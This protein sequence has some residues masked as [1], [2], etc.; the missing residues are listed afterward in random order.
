MKKLY[1][2]YYTVLIVL[3]IVFSVALYESYQEKEEL[4]GVI[5]NS[6]SHIINTTIN[7]FIKIKDKHSTITDETLKEFMKNLELEYNDFDI[8]FFFKENKNNL[9]D[10]L[11][12]IDILEKQGFYQTSDF[13]NTTY[14]LALKD[15]KVKEE[16]RDLFIPNTK[17][18]IGVLI[19]KEDE[20][21]DNIAGDLEENFAGKE[22]LFVGI[23]LVL[24]IGG[25]FLLRIL[26]EKNKLEIEKEV[27]KKNEQLKSE[28]LANMSHEIRTPLNAMFGFIKLLEEKVDDKEGKGYLEIIK[29][30]GGT[31]LSIIN[32]ILDFS[33]IEAGKMN[34]E[35]IPFNL[36]EEVRTIYSLFEAQAIEKDI[37]LHIT[38]KNI[39]VDV[40]TDPTRLK[41]IISNLLSNAIKFTPE[42]KNVYFDISY[43]DKKEEIFVKIKDEG[44]GIP[45]DKLKTIFQPFSQADSSTTRQYGGTGLGLSISNNLAEL[46]GGKLGVKSEEAKGSEFYFTIPA[47]KSKKITTPKKQNIENTTHFNYHILVAEDNKANQ[48][49]MEIM[50][51][52]LGLTFDMANDGVEALELYKEN[53]DK[54]KLILMDENMPNMTG[55]EAA[56]KI[57]EF[58]KEK[59]LKHIKIA[60]ITANALS[61]D[62]E[63]FL[64]SGFDYYLAKP[65]NID[66][67][68]E[69]LKNIS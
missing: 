14:Y 18:L 27:A 39:D 9:K 49:F 64:D 62:K 56:Q 4:K 24:A 32:D 59:G 40:I 43:D 16:Y 44:I 65:L 12:K 31:L 6:Y 58:E 69:I 13:F 20:K 61:G 52:K 5:L 51:K 50:L 42:G 35:K 1:R 7:N 67:L 33:K 47:K 66:D 48:M 22:I 2:I 53:Y 55:S 30:S 19:F 10:V 25:Y 57:I 11:K 21:K 63:K 46:L 23:W 3:A 38:E 41:Q 37:K 54:Y 36:K 28:F 45:K 68:Q 60:V 8:K 15:N 26:G 17:N 34:I 29:K